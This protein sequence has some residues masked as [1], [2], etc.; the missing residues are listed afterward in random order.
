MNRDFNEEPLFDCKKFKYIANS[1]PDALMLVDSTNG[2]IHQVNKTTVLLTGFEIGNL[3]H[4][5]IFDLY[6]ELS[7]V[8]Q[9]Q[10]LIRTSLEQPLLLHQLHLR[11]QDGNLIRVEINISY[12][13]QYKKV[14][15]VIRDQSAY[16]HIQL[17]L[18]A[19]NEALK[20][21]ALEHQRLSAIINAIDEGAQKKVGESYFKTIVRLLNKSLNADS[22]FIAKVNEEK[23]T[24][25]TLYWFNRSEELPNMIYPLEHTPC[26]DVFT[27]KTCIYPD[28]VQ[29]AF[30]FDQFFKD[31][32]IVGYIGVPINQESHQ[33]TNLIL[34]SLFKS[35]I[36][37]SE[38]KVKLLNIFSQRIKNESS[39]QLLAEHIQQQK[40]NLLEKKI[41]LKEIHHRVKNNMQVMTS[42]LSLQSSVLEDEKTKEI[43]KFSQ[44]RI[45]AMAMVHEMLY[46]SNEIS[47]I[48][49]QKYLD[50]LVAGLVSAM[51]KEEGKLELV[52]NAPN[53]Q[54]N[55]DT[56]IPLG[57]LINE[58]I[59]NS[60]KYAFKGRESG[61]I[62]LDLQKQT[63][64][65]LVLKI[66][67][68]GVGFPK[69]LNFKTIDSLGIKLIQKLAIQ[70]KGNL[71][72][73]FEKPG[74]N[75]ILHFQE[76]E[77]KS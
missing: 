44:Y 52:V 67:D 10:G 20:A 8:Q 31:E 40:E 12:S 34:V 62:T 14:L 36:Q 76:I 65:H 68:D 32:H 1:F 61:K 43:F 71:Q 77:Q 50:K 27:S 28:N 57:L 53:I 73:D 56:A 45:N 75:Y 11:K 41:L 35:P 23:N 42:L 21:S 17:E 9:L 3:I 64:P 13:Q 2:Q 49:Y 59:T 70:L 46:Q 54:I 15:F 51:Y 69:D 72:N 25:E 4:C 6:E 60:L 63:A 22:T 26:A 55:L 66:G 5:S 47:K 18:K 48:D 38:E 24:A 30:P 37:R 74:T 7:S 58:I 16:Q 19:K 29:E 33:K 39:R